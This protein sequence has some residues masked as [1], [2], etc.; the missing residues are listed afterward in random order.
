M[1][2]SLR[3][4]A[5]AGFLGSLLL[6]PA[7]PAL[8]A[9]ITVTTTADEF[10]TGA[11][12][13]LREAIQ[14]ANT[15]AAYGGCSAGSGSDRIV[16]PAGTYTLTISGS[17]DANTSGD[18]DILAD[19]EI[20][21]AGVATT[22]V[23]GNDIDRVFDVDPVETGV[24]VLMSDLTVRNGDAPGT[25]CAGG[26]WNHGALTLIRAAVIDNR[27]GC[28]AGIENYDNTQP[29][30]LQTL[31]LTDV[32]ISGNQTDNPSNGV[33]GGLTNE[34]DRTATLTNVTISNNTAE[35]DGGGLWHVGAA[36]TTTLNNVTITGNTA[37]SVPG[38]DGGGGIHNVNGTVNMANSIVAG[39]TDASGNTGPDCEGDITSQGYNLLGNDTGC[40]FTATTGDKIGTG[41]AP[42]N[43]MLGPLADNGGPTATHA[44]L[45]GSPALDAGNPATPGSGGT[46]CAAADQRGAP[47]NCDMGAYELVQCLGV[48]VNRVGVSTG[49]A[50]IT[51]TPGADGILGLG[52]NE[53]IDAAAGDDKVC[54]GPGDDT[55]TAG[56]G[57][58]EVLGEGGNDTLGGGAG[59]DTVRGGAGDDS[60]TGGD[61]DDTLSGEDGNDRLLGE[62]GNDNLDGGPGDDTLDGGDGNDTM[63]A[64]DGNDQ[65]LGEVG[66]DSLNGGA[67]NDTLDGGAGNDKITAGDGNDTGL[68]QAGKD[69][70]AGGAGNDRLKGHRGNDRLKG[71]AGKDRLNGGPGK[72][73]RCAGGGGKKDKAAGSCEKTLGIP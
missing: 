3:A 13:G 20:L 9:T 28:G 62:A 5:V 15:D 63:T 24:T 69:T 18:L 11:G 70:V 16:L 35:A 23:D 64:G 17:E 37:D 32:L 51:G 19:L 8:A 65:L 54:A 29:A 27:G 43:P 7:Q 71:Q 30:P 33:G 58:D 25:V 73:D 21:G 49:T 2:R 52:G 72:K 38:T 44:L 1:R 45:T 67:G 14:A 59:N 61:G 12:C 68:G 42:I 6:V 10:G 46:A 55:V 26:I 31:V 48:A 39:N 41:A 50:T 36:G 66:N 53:T 60:V 4:A 47:R 56:D 34:V 22:I 57:N 40:S